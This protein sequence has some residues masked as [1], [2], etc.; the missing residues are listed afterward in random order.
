MKL[1][2]IGMWGGFPKK[3]GPC[4]GYLIEH[5]NFSLLIDCGSGVLVKLQEFID[6]NKI[7]YII[8]SHYHYDHSSDI[9]AYLFSR[10]VNTQLGRTRNPLSIYGPKDFEM[11][12]EIS[13]VPYNE[14]HAIDAHTKLKIGP[15]NIE[16]IKT[17]HPVET[18]GIR[19]EGGGKQIVYTSD[20]SFTEELVK[21][22][23]GADLLIAE[24]SLYEGMDGEAFGH[25][26]SEEA[27]ILAARANTKETILTHLPHY[28]DIEELLVNAKAQGNSQIKLAQPGMVWDSRN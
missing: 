4:S 22:A 17:I 10:L 14:F 26:T 12:K 15:F 16:F 25:M 23:A 7:D 27:G 9:G 19:V 21:F 11:E 28:G 18:Y 6:L 20:T 1:T 3:D 5:N 8:L 2:V 24:S 13:A